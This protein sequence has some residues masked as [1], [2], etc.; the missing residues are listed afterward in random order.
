[1]PAAGRNNVD[2]VNS[3]GIFR[4][5]PQGTTYVEGN[6]W[7]VVGWK[8]DSHPPCPVVPI[9]CKNQWVMVEGSPTTY[10]EG[11][12]VCRIGDL[13]SCG[14]DETTGSGTVFSN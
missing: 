4:S 12:P 14:H 8:G 10:I 13:A 7:A 2:M 1:M 11:I 6:L 9:H 3:G 5:G